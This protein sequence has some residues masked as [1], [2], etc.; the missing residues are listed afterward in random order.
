VGR[1]TV[2]VGDIDRETVGGRECSGA[3]GHT[4]SKPLAEWDGPK[5][6]I[7]IGLH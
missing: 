2:G 6:Q 4:R 1:E 7:G 5:A 3:R